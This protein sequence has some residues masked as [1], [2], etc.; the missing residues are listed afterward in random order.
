MEEPNS[1]KKKSFPLYVMSG[2]VGSSGEQLARTVLAQFQNVNVEIEVFPKISTKLQVQQILQNA[3][4][5]GAVIAHT[6]VDPKLRRILKE[7]AEELDLVAIDLIGPLIETLSEKISQEPLGKP[8]LYRQLYQS[9][10]DRIN[11]MDY[12][13]AHDDGKNPQGWQDAEIVLLSASRV[14]KTP[15]SLYLSVLGWRVANIPLVAGVSPRDEFFELDM[16]RVIGL[17]IAPSELIEHRKHRQSHLGAVGGKSDYIDPV[18]IFQ[19]LE[20]VE[21]FFRRNRIPIIDV[22]G[23]PIESSADEVIR[24]LRRKL[25]GA[26]K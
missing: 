14:G 18:K 10:F 26:P 16:R 11:A 6:F 4:V 24:L 2:G 20:E 9:Y 23:K 13:L 8:G 25:K 1:Q 17:T 19:E 15:V 5:D 3:S 12:T 7:T 22:T 21:G